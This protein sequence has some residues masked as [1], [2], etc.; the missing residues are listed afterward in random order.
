MSAYESAG[1]GADGRNGVGS[2]HRWQVR[3][4]SNLMDDNRNRT[5][6]FG[7]QSSRDARPLRRLA[8]L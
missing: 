8:S 6:R 3:S 1:T 2:G 4:V 7:P 5:D